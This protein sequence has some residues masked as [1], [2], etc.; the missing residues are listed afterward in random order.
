[1]RF[2]FF[3][4]QSAMLLVCGLLAPPT[5][6]GDRWL[7]P[8]DFPSQVNHGLEFM[9][10]A[11]VQEAMQAY[12]AALLKEPS[13]VLRII[14]HKDASQQALAEQLRGWLLVFAVQPDKIELR[15]ARKPKQQLALELDD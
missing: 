11:E 14:H 13:T 1:M 2:L 9:R 5:F 4:K 6:A 8:I 3:S 12:N 15:A 7:L 10:N